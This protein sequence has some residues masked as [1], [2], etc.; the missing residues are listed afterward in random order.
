MTMAPL[1]RPACVPLNGSL[2]GRGC[3]H[4]TARPQPE[5]RAEVVSQG[6]DTFD[7]GTPH[8]DGEGGGGG[9]GGGGAAAPACVTVCDWPPAAIVAERESV[10]EFGWTV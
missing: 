9:G 6:E 10:E 3:Y 8:G 2:S 5:C 7:D 1:R 4:S